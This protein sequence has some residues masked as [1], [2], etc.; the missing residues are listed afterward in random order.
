M[1][2]LCLNGGSSSLKF[3]MYQSDSAS[4]EPIAVASG[5][6]PAS[7]NADK[8]LDAVLAHVAA[9][10]AGPLAAIG[11]RIVFGGARYAAPVRADDA[12]LRDI[13]GLVAVEPLHLRPELDL[14]YAASRKLPGLPQVLCFDTAFHRTE[15]PIARRLPLPPDLDPLLE[16]YG[17]HGLSYEYIVS[18][19]DDG[20]GRT[21]VAHLGSG[22][23]LCAL[24]N[25]APVD[26]TMGFSALGGLMM[27]TRPGDLDPG[28][29]LRLLDTGYDAARLSD[30]F[31]R[32]SGILGVS[33]STAG[34]KTLIAKAHTDARA[35]EAYDLFIYQLVKHLGAMI[36][37]LGGLDT[38][39]FTGGI[40]EHAPPVRMAAAEA[41]GYL[42]LRL[43]A[44][45]NARN[46]RIISDAGSG[47]VIM[48]L[49]TDENLMI[50]R[51][52]LRMVEGMP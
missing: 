4:S 34:M 22:A 43:D 49:P 46:E 35:R 2:I 47:V 11:H 45:A 31:Y 41:F 8:T 3:T 32:K 1:K 50:A 5:E 7:S 29:V 18:Q 51:H 19:L 23:S 10:G 24:R 37:V 26:T 30:L 20:S 33:G 16:R 12:V 48:V 15:P 6:T 25:R 44:A 14:V 13:E 17:F 36:A 38:L 9:R 40:G 39:V 42:G 52:T 27:G 21:V 28:V